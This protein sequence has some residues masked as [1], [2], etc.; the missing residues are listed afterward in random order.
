MAVKSTQRLGR[1]N[2]C[3][4]GP[5][6][7][8]SENMVPPNKSI[9]DIVNLFSHSL[10]ILA[11][12]FP[13][14]HFIQAAPS[15]QPNNASSIDGGTSCLGFPGSAGHPWTAW[16]IDGVHKSIHD[17]PCMFGKNNMV[18]PCLVSSSKKLASSGSR[19]KCYFSSH[20]NAISIG[21]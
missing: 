21:K 16:K 7:S 8:F 17:N 12:I 4:G 14:T 10:A 13:D 1:P 15:G 2:Y 20:P 6:K 9:G 11:K 19:F 3:W 5:R 18:N